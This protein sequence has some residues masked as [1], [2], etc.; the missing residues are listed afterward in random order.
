MWVHPDFD[1]G[2]GETTVMNDVAMLH[3]STPLNF[4]G[5]I[6]KIEFDTEEVATEMECIIVGWGRT[7]GTH[8]SSP[9]N[10]NAY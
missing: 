5:G 6:R 7:D 2:D 1:I 3:L 10:L 8:L 9:L 4:T